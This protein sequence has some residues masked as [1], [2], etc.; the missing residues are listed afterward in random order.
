M[1]LAATS[2]LKVTEG[3]NSNQSLFLLKASYKPD[4]NMC[5][6]LVDYIYNKANRL[7]TAKA[8]INLLGTY[9]Y[10]TLGQRMSKIYA[11]GSKELFH[12]DEAGQLIAVT[13]ASG[14]TLR[15]YIYNGNTLVGYV[16][17]GIVAYVHN[18]H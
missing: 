14:N 6:N 1:E 16:N 4:A 9:V 11:D 12:Y 3:F 8:G 2:A 18:D 7:T 5:W 13:N 15:E 17:A 10:N